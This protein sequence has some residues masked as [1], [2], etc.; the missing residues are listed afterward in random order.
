MTASA[1]GSRNQNSGSW[2]LRG[3]RTENEGLV[4]LLAV[5]VKSAKAAKAAKAK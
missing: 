2:N 1:D 4:D 3:I 5:E